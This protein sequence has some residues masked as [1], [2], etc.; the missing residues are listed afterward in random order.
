MYIPQGS[1]SQKRS[2]GVSESEQISTSEGEGSS[3]G[4]MA[5]DQ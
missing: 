3:F 5:P 1:A 2:K 4:S